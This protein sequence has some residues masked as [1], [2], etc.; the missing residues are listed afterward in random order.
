MTSASNADDYLFATLDKCCEKNYSW[1]EASYKIGGSSAAA[2][3][4]TEKWYIVWADSTCKKD[5]AI[6]G[7]DCVGSVGYFE[8]NKLHDTKAECAVALMYRMITRSVLH[9]L[10]SQWQYDVNPMTQ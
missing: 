9:E 1:N 10:I 2:G 4:G 6:G 7:T 8:T 5:C 3:T